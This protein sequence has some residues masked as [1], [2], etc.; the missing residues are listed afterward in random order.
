ML[1]AATADDLP[2]LDAIYSHYVANTVATFDLEPLGQ[3]VWRERFALCE[4]RGQPWV[5]AEED[6]EVVAYA[7][8]TT[9][10]AKAAYG[11]T[12]ESTVYVAAGHEGH[13]LGSAV[14]GQVLR[15]AAARGFHVAV[16]G[17]TLPN[18]ASVALHERLGFRPVGVFHEI[19][20]KFGAWHD[21]GWFQLPLQRP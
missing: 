13:G 11:Q 20:H 5:V 12:V 4:E 3:E 18:P 6:G 21:V 2:R 7:T 17:V 15:E 14:Y 10:R 1:R 8:T 9:H 16:A 19:G